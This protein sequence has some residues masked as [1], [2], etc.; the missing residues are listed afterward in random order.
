MNQQWRNWIFYLCTTWHAHYENGTENACGNDRVYFSLFSFFDDVVV[1]SRPH[2]YWN[3]RSW[4]KNADDGVIY[5]LIS[6]TFFSW[7]YCCCFQFLTSFWTC[8]HRR[9]H[10]HFLLIRP[11]RRLRLSCFAVAYD[12]W[13]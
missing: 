2:Y 9:N 6:L 11:Y 12:C 10:N 8:A 13:I 4:L 1:L 7:I 5:F 3:P